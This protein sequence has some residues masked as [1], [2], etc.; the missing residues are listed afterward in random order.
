MSGL[1]R[2]GPGWPYVALLGALAIAG[3]A[4]AFGPAGVEFIVRRPPP[5]RVEVR[6]APPG[7]ADVWIG[8]YYAW[9]RGDYVWIGGRWD[10]PPQPMYRRWAPGHWVHARQGWYWVEGR[11]R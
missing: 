5:A 4:P 2:I 6:V 10:R 11:W 7:P 1:R 9:Q 3:C 8:G